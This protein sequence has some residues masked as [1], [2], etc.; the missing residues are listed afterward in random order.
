MTFPDGC[1]HGVVTDHPVGEVSLP[2]GLRHVLFDHL[3]TG[4]AVRVA[5]LEL[6]PQPASERR[7]LAAPDQD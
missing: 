7:S 1:L 5:F 6:R 4:G 2:H 3:Q